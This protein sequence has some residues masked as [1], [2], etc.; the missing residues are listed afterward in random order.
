[1]RASFLLCGPLLKA[2]P[3]VARPLA[4]VRALS[5]A[6]ASDKSVLGRLYAL[7]G[8]APTLAST[9]WVAPGSHLIGDVTLGEEASVWFN[10][11]LRA[12]NDP[13]TIG[14]RSNVQD[15]TVVH[16]DEGAP[17]VVGEDVTVGHNVILHGCTV[18]DG[19]LIGMGATVLNNATIGANSLVGAGALVKENERVPPNSLVVGAPAKVIRTFTPAQALRLREGAAGYVKNSEK[20]RAYLDEVAAA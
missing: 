1:M 12:D 8:K 7:E 16:T 2:A 17:C 5:G 15:G 20:F 14:A 3:K 19:A 6:D 11:V 4:A 18:E 13:I 10:C 9:V